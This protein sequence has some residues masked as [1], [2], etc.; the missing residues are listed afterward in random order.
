MER[1]EPIGAVSEVT[2]D[3]LIAY[4][5]VDEADEQ[6]RA[7]LGSMLLAAKSYMCKHTGLDT[8]GLDGGQDLVIALMVL[9]QDMWDN[10]TLYPD[11][12]SGVNR[13]VQSILAL[14]ARNLL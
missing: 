5:R 1:T 8:D 13:V 9:V 6:D 11:K 3:D 10:R 4:L 14:H 2:V 7:L 12:A